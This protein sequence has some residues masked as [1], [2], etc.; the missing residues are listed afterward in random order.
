MNFVLRGEVC[1]FSLTLL[2]L[3]SFFFNRTK[4][5]LWESQQFRHNKSA[6][7]SGQTSHCWVKMKD[8]LLKHSE[9]DFLFFY[10]ILCTDVTP[11][12]SEQMSG[13]TRRR[14]GLCLGRECKASAALMRINGWRTIIYFAPFPPSSSVWVLFLPLKLNDLGMIRLLQRLERRRSTA[15]AFWLFI[16]TLCA[17]A[18]FHQRGAPLPEF[19]QCSF[20]YLQRTERARAKLLIITLFR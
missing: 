10:F 9:K 5:F 4:C 15:P 19:I 11:P 6:V 16:C 12:D 17:A 2:P 3:A 13:S 8:I 7:L 20:R 18:C 1:V 14:E